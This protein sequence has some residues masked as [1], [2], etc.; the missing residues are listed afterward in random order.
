M[1]DRSATVRPGYVTSNDSY[2]IVIQQETKDSDVLS[3]TVLMPLVMTQHVLM[4]LAMTPHERRPHVPTPHVPTPHVLTPLA[5]TLRLLTW[6]PLVASR[7]PEV[8]PL[9]AGA[10]S[11]HIVHIQRRV[12]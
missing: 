2:D 10:E 8:R 7:P 5:L 11:D 3:N 12:R 4:P 1:L 6:V 9:G